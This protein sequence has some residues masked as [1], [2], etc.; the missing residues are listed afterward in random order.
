LVTQFPR[1]RE[2][3]VYSCQRRS[4]NG[5][6]SLR[7]RPTDLSPTAGQGRGWR[8]FPGRLVWLHWPARNHSAQTRPTS[9]APLAVCYTSC[10]GGLKPFPSSSGLGWFGRRLPSEV[11][12][13]ERPLEP[14]LSSRHSGRGSQPPGLGRSRSAAPGQAGKFPAARCTPGGAEVMRPEGERGRAPQR[15][16]LVPKQPGIQREPPHH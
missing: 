1:E 16:I 11:T 5:D 7:L 14:G 6:E 12:S 8:V 9:P 4:P 13:P 2:G 3:R 15:R 10:C